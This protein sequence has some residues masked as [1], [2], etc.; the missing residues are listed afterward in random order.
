MDGPINYFDNG[1]DSDEAHGDDLF[2]S[3]N[4]EIPDDDF[5]LVPSSASPVDPSVDAPSVHTYSSVL[6]S[7][8]SIHT[9]VAGKPSSNHTKDRNTSARLNLVKIESPMVSSGSSGSSATRSSQLIT[10]PEDVYAYSEDMPNDA[11][12]ATDF[13]SPDPAPARKRRQ[14]KQSSTSNT[15]HGAESTKRNKF[16]ERNRVAAT[17]CRQKKKE[18]VSDLEETRFGLESQHSH[19]QMEYSSLKNEITQIKSQLMEHA[20][21]NDSNI[22]KWI[23]N[24]AKKFVLGAGGRYDQMLADLGHMP[25]MANRHGSISSLAGYPEVPDA[26]LTRPMTPANR[27]N[28]SFPPGAMMPQSPVFY[29]ADMTPNMPGAASPVVKEPYSVDG[30]RNEDAT[31]FDSVAIANNTFHT[32][33]I[34]NG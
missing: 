26:E 7:T 24:E 3:R 25:N 14:R 12:G 20:S 13:L 23:E 10:P 11:T 31:N 19:L 9:Q 18:W 6:L 22:D 29:R 33:G 32:S 34:P 4:I 15:M 21:C 1:F 27:D 8:D 5:Q 30:V 16:L 2:D 17:K 28:I